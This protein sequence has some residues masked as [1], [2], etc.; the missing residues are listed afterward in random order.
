MVR[1][2]LVGI[3]C[4]CYSNGVCGRK[5]VES[6]PHVKTGKPECEAYDK[7][8]GDL[9]VDIDDLTVSVMGSVK[10]NKKEFLN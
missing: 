5:L 3:S 6:E 7:Y 9:L 1:V 10:R 8:H 4:S 2:L